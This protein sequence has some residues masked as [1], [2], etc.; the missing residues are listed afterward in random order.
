[1]KAVRSGAFRC[2]PLE[3]VR[4]GSGR[5]GT[6]KNPREKGG[7]AESNRFDD[8]SGSTVRRLLR[9]EPRT[10][11]VERRRPGPAQAGPEAPALDE[12]VSRPAASPASDSTSAAPPPGRRAS[13]IHFAA[14]APRIAPR[15]RP[16]RWPHRL[17]AVLG[18][19][20]RA[21]CASGVPSP[22]VRA[23]RGGRRGGRDCR[24]LAQGNGASALS[25]RARVLHAA[26]A[27]TRQR[28]AWRP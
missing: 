26:T 10:E 5:F 7:S 12:G 2:T 13:A 28:G 24:L 14:I 9:A 25:R 3:P 21:W 15:L 8:R 17:A 11:P 16:G 27:S 4:G 19:G 18:R 22:V 6:I 23:G 1:V 20:R